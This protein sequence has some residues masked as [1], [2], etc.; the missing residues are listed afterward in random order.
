[1]SPRKVT[2]AEKRR[3]AGDGGVDNMRNLLTHA[4][5][6]KSES[7]VRDY[8][9]IA[10][11]RVLGNASLLIMMVF[12]FRGSLNLVNLSFGESASLVFNSFLSVGFFIQHSG[13]I[14]KS[15]QSWSAQFVEE[16]Y[17]GAL[18]TIA[19]SILLLL[20]IVFWQKSYFVLASAQGGIRWLLRAIFALSV[21]GFFWGIR[22]LGSLDMFGL[23]PIRKGMQGATVTP[24]RFRVRGPY[25]WVRH[26]L[27][28]FCL[29]MIWSCP[30]LTADRLLFNLLWT[31]W[32]LVGTIL[33]ERDLVA[34]FGEDY[35]VYQTEVPMLIPHR[36]RPAR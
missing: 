33:E 6:N 20:L 17:H 18:F 25:R 24:R 36:I 12:L 16:K 30:D 23:D 5:R 14:R 21:F 34:L 3:F 10:V 19:S 28:L 7:S 22:S 11:T 35:Q 29:L 26:P 31:A 13:M 4:D 1:M 32:I 27:Y 8:A 9:L 2:D 15:F